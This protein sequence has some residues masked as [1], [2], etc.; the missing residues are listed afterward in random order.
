MPVC[1]LH[2]VSLRTTLS[3]FLY[4]LWKSKPEPLVVSRVIRWVIA[5]ESL[6]V[7]PLLN[8]N[9]PWDLV[10]I[11]PGAAG[12]SPELREHVGNEWTVKVGIP[13]RLISGFRERNEELLFPKPEVVPPLSGALN[14]PRIAGSAQGLELTEEL[15]GWVQGFS[16]REGQQAVSM[17]NLLA[18]KPGMKD[19]YLKYGDAFAKSV[20]KR[21]GGD[22]K[23]VGSVI[24]DGSGLG[25][26]TGSKGKVWDEIALA[27]YP[28]IEH[29]AD[30]LA[31]E[32]YQEVNHQHR[33]GSLKDTFILCTS[34]LDLLGIRGR[35][36]L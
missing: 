24:D 26:G 18:F 27:H 25:S 35:E 19:E 29:F 14:H 6:S 8:Q 23:I 30:M 34:E 1:S 12:L 15:R 3:D 13:S 10:V 11:L 21:R 28:S 36:R 32:D 7:D 2:L 33:V 16:Q 5:P 22:A 20:G 4:L 9:I 31:S 17:L